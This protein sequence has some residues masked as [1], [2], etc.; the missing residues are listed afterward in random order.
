MTI[1]YAYYTKNSKKFINTNFFQL[2]SGVNCL[3]YIKQYLKIIEEKEVSRDSLL[4]FNSY[5]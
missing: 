2:N 4:I 3:N 1:Y 5:I